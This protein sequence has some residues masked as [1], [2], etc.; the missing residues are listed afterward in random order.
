MGACA[1]LKRVSDPQELL[2]Q[3]LVSW[4]WVLGIELELFGRAEMHFDC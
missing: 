4:T 3:A 2:L 1:G